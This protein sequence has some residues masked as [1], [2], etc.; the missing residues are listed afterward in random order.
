MFSK[1]HSVLKMML[2][3]AEE[4]TAERPYALV[5]EEEY[6]ELSA[7]LNLN[8]RKLRQVFRFWY[9]LGQQQCFWRIIEE[10]VC[11]A[12]A[13]YHKYEFVH[14]QCDEYSSLYCDFIV[15]YKGF[16]FNLCKLK[17]TTTGFK[18]FIPGEQEL[19]FYF[20]EK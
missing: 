8:A 11:R 19:K 7:S 12:L 1:E 14:V 15:R 18:A 5:L 13:P 10:D 3:I 16:K 20:I 9:Q 4:V 17:Y 6:N 2:G